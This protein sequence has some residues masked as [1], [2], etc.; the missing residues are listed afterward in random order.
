MPGKSVRGWERAI[1]AQRRIAEAVNQAIAL[2]AADTDIAIISHGAVGALLLCHRKGV[3]IP[4]REDQPSGEGA[5]FTRS[6]WPPAGSLT[7]GTASMNRRT[8][9]NSQVLASLGDGGPHHL[10]SV[11]GVAARVVGTDRRS[12]RIPCAARFTI[13]T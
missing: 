8:V 1:D 10:V 2:V 9:L 11:N 4:R 6:T 3:P 7:N 5:P 12:S 13:S